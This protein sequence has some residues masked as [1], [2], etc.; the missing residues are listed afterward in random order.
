MTNDTNAIDLAY[1]RVAA[2]VNRLAEAANHL[3]FQ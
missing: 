3:K 1:S 2:A